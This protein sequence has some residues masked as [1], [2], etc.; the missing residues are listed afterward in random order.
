MLDGSFQLNLKLELEVGV[1][2]EK[3]SLKNSFRER[4]KLRDIGGKG[5]RKKRLNS[6]G[7]VRKQ[8]EVGWSATK[9]V[10]VS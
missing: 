3:D 1:E 10:F 8:G 7:N 2:R 6:C 9:Q 5:R 4:K